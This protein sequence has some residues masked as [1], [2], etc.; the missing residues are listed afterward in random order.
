[1]AQ[2][3]LSKRQ[4]PA[5]MMSPSQADLAWAAGFLEGEGNFS[6][7][8][9]RKHPSQCV[10]AVQK[11]MEPLYRLQRMFGGSVGAT[12]MSRGVEGARTAY[13]EWRAY[14]V[15]ARGIMMTLYSL[16]SARRREQVAFALNG[17]N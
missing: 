6:T 17:G 10:R 13:G 9:N 2:T 1:M 15:R 12:H 8:F 7:N 11:N 14:G 16:M 5:A 3:H 4:S